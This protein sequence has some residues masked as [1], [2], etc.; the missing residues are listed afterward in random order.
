ML[1]MCNFV[2]GFKQFNKSVLKLLVL[3]KNKK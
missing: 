3:S 1:Q 2:M